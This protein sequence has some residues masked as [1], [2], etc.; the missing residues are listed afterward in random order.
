LK[1]NQPIRTVL[2]LRRHLETAGLSPEQFAKLAKISNMTIRRWLEKPDATRI[3]EKYHLPLDAAATTGTQEEIVKLLGAGKGD[4]APFL[5]ELEKN[6]RAYEDLPALKKDTAT[7][8]KD[9]KIGAHLRASVKT[10]LGA[11][12]LK[13]LPL[14]Y[15]AICIG[16]MLYFI[17]PV[18]LIPDT[19]PVVGYLDDFA[20]LSLAAGLVAK[21]KLGEP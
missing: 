5:D 4:F 13:G 12:T 9:P 15:K 7:K 10:V 18:D 11:V 19:I 16:A 6:G 8:L 20:V 1:D 21:W 3:P 14:R 17:N 2:D